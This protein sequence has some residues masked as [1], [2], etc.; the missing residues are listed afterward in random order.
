MGGPSAIQIAPSPL[1]QANTNGLHVIHDVESSPLLR[2]LDKSMPGN[3]G[4]AFAEALKLKAGP[5]GFRIDA[6][7]LDSNLLKNSSGQRVSSFSSSSSSST[8]RVDSQA[9]GRGGGSNLFSKRGNRGGVRGGSGSGSA[10]SRRGG[11]GGRGGV[12]KFKVI[13]GG[14]S[15]NQDVDET[16]DV[17]S[18][19]INEGEGL[20][21]VNG[22]TLIGKAFE[23]KAVTSPGGT[24]TGIRAKRTDLDESVERVNGDGDDD[25]GLIADNDEEE[26]NEDVEEDDELKGD[27]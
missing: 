5:G 19:L 3:V 16:E 2:D 13:V 24:V 18:A 20:I 25:D 12:G 9:G 26:I 11:G 4:Q 27:R 1:D 15:R 10:P 6:L 14:A 17:T 8:M 23:L 21:R 7:M 22:R